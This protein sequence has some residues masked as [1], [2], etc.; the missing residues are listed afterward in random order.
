M[1]RNKS[2]VVECLYA[3]E[4]KESS[5]AWVT[6]ARKS[7]RGTERYDHQQLILIGWVPLF[8]ETAR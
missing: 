5:Q 1:R 2:N 7:V 3:H 4:R 8:G 6:E